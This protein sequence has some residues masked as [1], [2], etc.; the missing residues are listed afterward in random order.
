VDRGSGKQ[1]T[2]QQDVRML[3]LCLCLNMYEGKGSECDQL[4]SHR[5]IT[6]GVVVE[7]AGVL[8]MIR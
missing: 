6:M 8:T 4:S 3:C 2:L 1:S 7:P 5:M